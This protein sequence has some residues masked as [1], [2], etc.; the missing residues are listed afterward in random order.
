MMYNSLPQNILLSTR[1]KFFS[2]SNNKYNNNYE[3]SDIQFSEKEGKIKMNLIK[4]LDFS[5][6]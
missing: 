2:T 5:T 3:I 4:N 1:N 6:L